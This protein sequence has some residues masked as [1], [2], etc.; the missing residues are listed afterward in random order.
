VNANVLIKV[1]FS[2]LEFPIVMDPLNWVYMMMLGKKL[3]KKQV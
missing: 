1:A 2:S 3:I